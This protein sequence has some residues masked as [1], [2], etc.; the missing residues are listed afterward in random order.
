MNEYREVDDHSAAHLCVWLDNQKD[1]CR[2]ENV[3]FFVEL[4]SSANFY[5]VYAFMLRLRLFCLFDV[6]D[7]GSESLFC[8]QFQR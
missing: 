5:S 4:M 6:A 8:F 7:S 2:V 3:V 1:S